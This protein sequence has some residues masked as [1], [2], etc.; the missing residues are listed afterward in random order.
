M[1]VMKILIAAGCNVNLPEIQMMQAP[2][3]IAVQL[4]MSLAC[5]SYQ[6]YPLYKF[7]NETVAHLKI[8]SENRKLKLCTYTDVYKPL[9]EMKCQTVLITCEKW[10][11][12]DII[13]K[14]TP[15]LV[16]NY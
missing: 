12:M 16:N 4:G 11:L 10:V 3:H 14:L 1:E 9:V 8:T 7:M 6:Q 2:I 15:C 13:D 5:S